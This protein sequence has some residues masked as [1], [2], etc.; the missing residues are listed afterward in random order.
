MVLEVLTSFEQAQILK[1]KGVYFNREKNPNLLSH[2]KIMISVL[3]KPN[4]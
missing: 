2:S 1:K 4:E 3:T